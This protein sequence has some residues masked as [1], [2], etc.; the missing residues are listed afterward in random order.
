MH[1]THTLFPSL[2]PHARAPYDLAYRD[3]TEKQRANYGLA[4]DQ[5]KDGICNSP[6]GAS[7][8]QDGNLIVAEW[9]QFGHLHKFARE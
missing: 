7:I 1:I 6:H 9:S 2:R 4:Q 3:L 8:D 5:W